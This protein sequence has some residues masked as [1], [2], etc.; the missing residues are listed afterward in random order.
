[1]S[2]ATLQLS[3][4]L[5]YTAGVVLC[6]LLTIFLAKLFVRRTRFLHLR[7][8][9]LVKMH[10]LA[11]RLLPFWFIFA[12]SQK[13]MPS[14]N[15]ILGHLPVV[16]RLMSKLPSDSSYQYLPGLLRRAY[17]DLGPKFYTDTW[18]F[19]SPVLFIC[20]PSAFHQITQEHSLPKYP[21]LR[22]FLRPSANGPDIVTMEGPMWKRRSRGAYLSTWIGPGQ[23]NQKVEGRTLSPEPASLFSSR[24]ERNNAALSCCIQSSRWEPG[25]HVRDTEGR[26]FP[27]D[28]FLVWAV[29]QAL[30]RDKSYWPQPEA[31]LPDRWT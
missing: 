7:R 24:S 18:P 5:A 21:D 29:S 20:E 1:M 28:G 15:P 10:F 23:E 12:K 11:D 22:E 17:P 9:G 3:S 13:P 6:T 16:A 2:R 26:L 14:Y 27:T 30:H 19:G 4:A 8:Q 25:Y 31:F